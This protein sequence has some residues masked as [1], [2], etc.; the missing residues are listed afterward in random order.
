MRL[1]FASLL[2]SL[3][4]AAFAEGPAPAPDVTTMASNDCARARK[5]GKTCVLTIED[6]HIDGQ[7]AT[8]SG[9]MIQGLVTPTMASLITI[10]RD[11]IVEILKTAEDI[12]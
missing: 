6:E 2:I 1:I 3:P 5:A 11:F 7:V 8:G 4:V 12:D 10:R 9:E